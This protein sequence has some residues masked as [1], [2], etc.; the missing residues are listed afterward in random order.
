MTDRGSTAGV[1]SA[2]LRSVIGHR[3]SVS[4]SCLA[5]WPASVRTPPTP[6]PRPS[7]C[8]RDRAARPARPGAGGRSRSTSARRPVVV[9]IAD[10]YPHGSAF[11]YDLVYYGLEPGD[12][13]LTEFLRRKDGVARRRTSRRS[14][15]TVRAV[16]RRA[17]SSRTGSSRRARRALGGYRR[18]LAIGGAG[19]GRRAWSRSST[20][21][22][23]KPARPPR[24]PRP[25]ADAGRP[26]PAA[27]RGGR[28]PARSSPGS[29]PSW[30][31]S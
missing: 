12:Y 19:S 28:W 31:G 18:L 30:S 14:R 10:V 25:A 20:L 5:D 8:P 24:P 27:G 22:R 17:R 16:C 26:A 6:A 11:R 21:G 2:E 1:V 3:S 7:A 9:R 13:D 4:A 29:T 15:S 23:R